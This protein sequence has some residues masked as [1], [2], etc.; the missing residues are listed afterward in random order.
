MEY[1]PQEAVESQS[2]HQQ[3]SRDAAVRH[4][5]EEEEEKV[6]HCLEEDEE[7][8]HCLKEEEHYCLEQEEHNCVKEKECHCLAEKEHWHCCKEDHLHQEAELNKDSECL[9]GKQNLTTKQEAVACTE[10]VVQA[11]STLPDITISEIVLDLLRVDKPIN[12]HWSQKRVLEETTLKWPF[13]AV[14]HPGFDSIIL[15][16]VSCGFLH[17]D[18]C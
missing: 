10:V 8:C 1:H 13:H 5:V 7:R 15:A 17:V 18:R 9:H 2:L 3:E 4:C 11:M 16:V 14:V 12:G 6:C